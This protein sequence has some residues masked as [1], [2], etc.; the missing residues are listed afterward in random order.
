MVVI[1]VIISSN[2]RI[3]IVIIVISI[4][5]IIIINIINI[6]NINNIIIA[7]AAYDI[8]SC[9][10]LPVRLGVPAARLFSKYSF[11]WQKRTSTST[12]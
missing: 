6:N 4:G 5:I 9:S 11:A 1:S 8:I 7:D 10:R 2:S 3:I 12:H